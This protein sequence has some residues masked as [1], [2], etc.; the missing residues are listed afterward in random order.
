M[1]QSY[2]TAAK[3]IKIYGAIRGQG[4]EQFIAW[5]LNAERL[6]EGLSDPRACPDE[7]SDS[8]L[9]VG[10]LPEHED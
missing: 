3:A 6:E 9:L 4:R 8:A 1:D 5:L 2:L 10:R 7:R